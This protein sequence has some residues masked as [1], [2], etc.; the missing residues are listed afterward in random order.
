MLAKVRLHNGKNLKFEDVDTICIVD[1]E[2]ILSGL[3]TEKSIPVS[4]VKT[5]FTFDKLKYEDNLN[6]TYNEIPVGL[7]DN[8]RI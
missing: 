5:M 8:N 7:M 3:H 6:K 2:L 1:G 4:L